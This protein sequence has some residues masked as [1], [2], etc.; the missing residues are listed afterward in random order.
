GG[1]ALHL[2]FN[3]GGHVNA[4]AVRHVAVGPSSMA[5]GRGAGEVEQ[6]RLNEQ[7]IRALDVA[8]GPGAR[9]ARGGLVKTAA[10]GDGAGTGALRRG[11]G[12]RRIQRPVELE[13]ARPV[14]VSPEAPA[15]MCGEPVARELHELG[16]RD[17]AEDRAG[18]RQLVERRDGRCGE[19]FAAKRAK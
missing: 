13:N 15:V 14:A 9:F 2:A 6:R 7:D 3:R 16:G 12:D 1:E 17:V 11:P 18:G 10:E 4:R 5:A 19:D 8:A